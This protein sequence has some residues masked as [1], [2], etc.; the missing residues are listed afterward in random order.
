[1]KIGSYNLFESGCTISSCEIGDLNE[2]NHK[3]FVE[4]NCR[5]G[6]MCQ[7]GPKVTL[8]VGTKLPNN[9]IAYED[10]KIM[11][12]EESSNADARKSKIKEVSSIL[13]VQLQKH[14]K[15]RKV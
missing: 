15:L 7:I 2:F 1:M 10:S 3:C 12:N 13:A 5:I 11:I 14:N 4:D 6:T 8:P 9:V